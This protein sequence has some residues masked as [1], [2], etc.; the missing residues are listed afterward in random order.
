MVAVEVVSADIGKPRGGLGVPAISVGVPAISV[1]VPTV[2]AGAAKKA[3][4][5][6]PLLN[7]DDPMADELG[8]GAARGPASS[9]TVRRLS[10]GS[11]ALS[12]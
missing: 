5:P 9:G 2:S 1:G 4:P 10:Q 7:L 11:C 3:G 12:S 6:K 8:V